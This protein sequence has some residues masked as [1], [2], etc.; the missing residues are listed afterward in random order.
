MVI[1]I[2]IFLLGTLVGGAI[3]IIFMCLLQINI[4]YGRNDDNN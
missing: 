4:H 3:G 1:I 2:G